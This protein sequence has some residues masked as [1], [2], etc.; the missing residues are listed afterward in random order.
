MKKIIKK[1]IIIGFIL[2]VIFV[3]AFFG[4]NNYLMPSIVESNEV[5]LPNVVGLNKM[6]AIRRLEALNLT[7]VEVGP[8]YDSRYET[9]EVIFQKPYSGTMVKENRRVYIHISGGE[10]LVKM[11]QVVNKTLRD[12]RVN[13]ERLGLFVGKVEEILSEMP[14]GIVV[15]Q[16]YLLEHKLEKGDSVDLKISIGPQSGMVRVPNLIGKSVKAAVRILQHSNLKLGE[17][18]YISS[19]SLLPNTIVSQTPSQDFLL[20]IGESVDI[21]ISKSKR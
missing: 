9:D 8:R 19:P 7:P 16:E 2:T 1:L 15:E 18:S 14:M 5:E 3:G 10:P 17:K 20:N 6:D 4:V 21:V 13:I 11:P 12:A